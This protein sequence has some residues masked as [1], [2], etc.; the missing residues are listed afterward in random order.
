MRRVIQLTVT[1]SF[2]TVS[3]IIGQELPRPQWQAMH[4]RDAGL[5]LTGKT[6]LSEGSSSFKDWPVGVRVAVG[7]VVGAGAGALVGGFFALDWSQTR[8]G[9]TA[10]CFETSCALIGAAVGGGAGAVLPLAFWAEER[11][12]NPIVVRGVAGLVL[13]AGF[14]AGLGISAENRDA[15]L[16]RRGEEPISDCDET[17]CVLF[18]AVAVGILGAGAGVVWGVI[19]KRKARSNQF[20]VSV[21]PQRDGR[22]ALG[23]SVGF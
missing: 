2:L 11:G 17:D 10:K 16:V 7:G 4:F 8:G 5:T 6:T 1:I 20:R 22:F 3:P 13:G 18:G 23:L 15:S 9:R 21:V 19:S 12:A 14:G